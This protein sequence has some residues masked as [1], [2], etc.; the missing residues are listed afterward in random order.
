LL[1]NN[2][3][4]RYDQLF[5]GMTIQSWWQI[6]ASG[7]S[8]PFRETNYQPEIAYLAPTTWHP[9]SGN[10]GVGVGIE[11]Q[12]NGRSQGL[13]RSWNRVYGLFIY[14]RG[15]F[16]AL[17]RPWYRIP[18]NAKPHPD[19]PS[20]DDNPDIIDYMGNFELSLGYKWDELELTTM[21]R[22]NFATN[23]G[24]I[25]IGFSFPLYG[26]ILGYMQYFN[27]YGESLIDYNHKQQRFGLGLALTNAF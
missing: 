5:F 17:L 7:I 24:A 26:R 13:S 23:K 20:G 4:S 16:V 19:S 22:H 2:L 8:K 15:N 6:Y 14:E 27:G 21:T 11:H 25:E 9:F 3:F 10:V 18:E 1:K 12:S